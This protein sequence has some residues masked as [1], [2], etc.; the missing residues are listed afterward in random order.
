MSLRTECYYYLPPIPGERLERPLTYGRLLRIAGPL[1]LS[2]M[3]IML[4]QMVAGVFLARYGE[5]AIA[6]VGPAGMSFW[7]VCGLFVGVAGYSST[8]VAQY[9]GAGR[10]RRVGPAVWQALY[11]ALGGG[12]LLALTAPAAAPFFRFVGHVPEVQAN[13]VVYF[14]ILAWGGAVFLLSAA[15]S[16]FF[17][18]RHD[19]TVLMVA[20]IA[21]GVANAVLD[22]LLIFGLLG[23]PRM[24]MAGA[25]WATVIGHAVQVAVL[26]ARYFAP[27][28][29]REFATWTGRGLEPDLLSRLIRYGFPNGVRF[30]IEISVWTVFLLVI[31]RFDPA[32][33]AA[34][35][36]AWRIGGI[37]YFPV[38]G[39]SIAVSMLVGQAQ[40]CGRPDQARLATRRGLLVG[41][42]WMAAFAALMVFRPE[43][44]L[45]L[46]IGAAAHAGDSETHRLSILLMRFMACYCLADNLN[47]ILMGMLS[48]AGDTRWL[49]RVSA[50][51]HLLFA[52]ALGALAVAG[53]DTLGFW[54]AATVF[55]VLL[56]AVWVVRYRSP[57]WESR[58]VIE[59]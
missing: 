8:F 18:G 36:I 52:A 39:L 30:V 40:G 11:L 43:P 7:M 47:I 46:F 28:F 29:R 23:F 51:A 34:S 55:V 27:R 24:G 21:G 31:G 20:H 2:Q 56:S 16:G 58:R 25:A 17:A 26:G 19:N 22:A 5:A 50:I 38:L 9:V 49:L 45:G 42:G 57:A 6:A 35:N 12:A 53:A 15:L 4:M 48:G 10:P 54:L 13:E 14:T 1:V 3:G 44:L 41:W 33:L 59:R 32:G 37:A